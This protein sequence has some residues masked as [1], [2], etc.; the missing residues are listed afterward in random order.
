MLNIE[1]SEPGRV[2]IH[3]SGKINAEDMEAAL[4][5]L[6]EV[7]EDVSDGRLFYRITDFAVPDASA[8][9]VEFRYLPSLFGLIGKYKRCAVVCDKEWVRTVAELEGLLMPGLKIKSFEA[10]QED[11]AEDWLAAA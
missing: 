11:D 5:R 2:D 7:S 9:A 8:L 3:F 1:K 6:I 4:Q 10:G